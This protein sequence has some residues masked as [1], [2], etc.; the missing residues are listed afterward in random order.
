[1]AAL[2]EI[3][4]DK[5]PKSYLENDTPQ[6]SLMGTNPVGA[7]PTL[8]GNPDISPSANSPSKSADM[9]NSNSRICM[10]EWNPGRFESFD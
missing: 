9:T 3:I 2:T 10:P 7:N 6:A 8:C 1:M 4:L 5:F